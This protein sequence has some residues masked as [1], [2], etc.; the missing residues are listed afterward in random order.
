MVVENPPEL[1]IVDKFLRRTWSLDVS[2]KSGRRATLTL[3]LP[4]Q[5]LRY[6]V[7][8]HD[9]RDAGTDVVLYKEFF[10]TGSVAG[11][12]GFLR[13]ANAKTTT[14]TLV[15]QGRGNACDNASDF[16]NWRLE[17]KGPKS[18]FAIFGN[19]DVKGA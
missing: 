13:S 18:R 5:M 4:A 12:T 16:T 3:P 1:N 11:G 2:T 6:K 7:D 14:Y 10:F 8:T 9:R 19:M 17:L 15:F